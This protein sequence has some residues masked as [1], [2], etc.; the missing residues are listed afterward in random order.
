LAGPGAKPQVPARPVLRLDK[1]LWQARFFKA[2]A[3]AAE[4]VTEGRIRLNGTPLRKPGHAVAVGDVLT[5]AHGGR[6]RVIRVL[7]LGQRRGPS[8][9]AQA[10]YGD[11]DASPPQAVGDVSPRPLE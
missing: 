3:D 6:V 1:W 7:A 10:L 8:S 2:R 9:E 5:F 4:A 11:L